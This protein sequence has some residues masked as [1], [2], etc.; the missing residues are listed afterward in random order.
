MCDVQN[1]RWLDGDIYIYLYAD[2]FDFNRVFPEF[3]PDL[4]ELL[5]YTWY[6]LLLNSFSPS[7]VRS[8]ITLVLSAPLS[9]E[10]THTFMHFDRKCILSLRNH[11]KTLGQSVQKGKQLHSVFRRYMI[12]GLVRIN[13][14]F[15]LNEF[16]WP[17]FTWIY[18]IYWFLFD[19]NVAQYIWF[20]YFLS[21]W[22]YV[23]FFWF[24]IFFTWIRQIF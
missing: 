4:P 18:L 16:S 19:L 13:A 9:G 20:I 11:I 8:V 2:W 14:N 10:V 12:G 24:F 21:E 3:Y 7:T 15:G 6:I 1:T 17:G 23:I 5:E 22:I